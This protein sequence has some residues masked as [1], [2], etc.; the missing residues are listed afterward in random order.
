MSLER[1]VFLAV[2]LDLLIGDPRWFPHPVKLIGRLASSL[3]APARRMISTTRL[4][5]LVVTLAVVGIT[6]VTA[7]ALLWLSNRVHP[8]LGE[9]VSVFLLYSCLATRD[10]IRH[11]SDVY[12]ALVSGS[13]EEARRRVGMICGRD[14]D[15]L[16]ESG[17]ARAAVESVA[18]NMA[19]GVTAPLFFALI[20]GPVAMMAYKAVNTLDSTFGYKSERYRDFGWPAARLDDLANFVPARL[21][22]FLVPLAARLVGERA[23]DSLRIFLRD[24]NR[25]PSPNAGQPEAAVAGALG[26]QLGGVSHYFGE[27]SEKP[28]LGDHLESP[29]AA[30]I[31]RANALLLLTSGLFL[32]LMLGVRWFVFQ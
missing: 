12:R 24:R 31:L 5:G 23:W 19:D 16:D 4:A 6:A 29:T 8:A 17:V 25:H 32:A 21:T 18:E 10:M 11:S 22:G 26:V 7:W 20:G 14:T 27:P 2:A 3:E 30:H 9:C 28:S 1:Q 13:L 15:R